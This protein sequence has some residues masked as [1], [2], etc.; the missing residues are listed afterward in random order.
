MNDTARTVPGLLPAGFNELA[1]CRSG[2][3]L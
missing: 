3:M 2:P 1:R